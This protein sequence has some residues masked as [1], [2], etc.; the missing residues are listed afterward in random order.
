[1][2]RLLS[3]LLKEHNIDTD[4]FLTIRM[5]KVVLGTGEIEILCTSLTDEQRFPIDLFGDLYHRRW[6]A[7]EASKMLKSRAE[8]E[9]FSGK[10][11]KV[12]LQDFHAKIF[13]LIQSSMYCLPTEQKIRREYQA[14]QV[15]KYA[16]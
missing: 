2:Q 15:R 7:E 14:D 16:R 13:A 10:T 1:M 5:V 3:A 11:A 4:N 9:C 8:L 12:V 6:S